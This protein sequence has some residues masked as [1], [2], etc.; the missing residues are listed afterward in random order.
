MF[1]I[2]SE[3]D[4]FLEKYNISVSEFRA[5]MISWEELSAI[6]EDYRS[7][8]SEFEDILAECESVLRN[9]PQIHSYKFRLKDPEHLVEKI[10]RKNPDEI[11]KK[12]GGGSITLAN[13][14]KKITDLLG[15][16]VVF[17]YKDDWFSVHDYIASKY[18]FAK[19]PFAYV[20]R[21]DEENRYIE[22]GL[23]VKHRN[24]YRSVHYL[25]KQNGTFV[26]LQVRTLAEEVWGEI[27]HNIRYPYNIHNEML[28]RYMALMSDLT[29]SVDRMASFVYEYLSH[30]DKDKIPLSTNEVYNEVLKKMDEIDGNKKVKKEIIDLI[31]S[32]EEY[33]KI[34]D[35]AELIASLY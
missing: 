32:A 23:S 19:K 22:R 15:F 1:E 29:S 7:R 3:R 14:R 25:I 30:F 34:V 26:E 28:T 4:A 10:I 11:K 8:K 5:A 17:L 27:D 18:K 9:C 20:V 12:K 24:D 35:T 16:R 31:K 21:G 13:Y 2:D 6:A 33:A